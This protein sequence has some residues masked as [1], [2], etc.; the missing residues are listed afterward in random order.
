MKTAIPVIFLIVI[1][2]CSATRKVAFIKAIE[3]QNESSLLY[4]YRP[5]KSQNRWIKP[6]LAINQE[7]K[8]LLENGGYTYFYLEPGRY[9]IGL[10]LSNRYEEGT[11]IHVTLD[12]G[13]VQYIRLD[14]EFFMTGNQYS[15]TFDLVNTTSEH[16]PEEIMDCIYLDP[17]GSKSHKKSILTDN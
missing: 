4:V 16:G 14:T 17:A 2:S 8:I 10:I 11:T 7:E 12:S 6:G 9:E 15:R 3:P 13:G 5:A 1:G